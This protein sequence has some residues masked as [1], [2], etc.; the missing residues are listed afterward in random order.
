MMGVWIATPSARNDGKK[1][2]MTG[3]GV[4]GGESG[5]KCRFGANIV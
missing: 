5:G 4:T 2:V 1:D 3:G